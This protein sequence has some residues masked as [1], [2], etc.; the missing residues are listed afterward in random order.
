MDVL[1]QNRLLNFFKG[2]LFCIYVR[3]TQYACTN[4]SPDP[5]IVFLHSTAD[6]KTSSYGQLGIRRITVAVMTHKIWNE[7]V[8]CFTKRK[9]CMLNNIRYKM[10][11]SVTE[12]RT[13][14]LIW[15]LETGFG[16]RYSPALSSASMDLLV[17][18]PCED[19]ATEE[20][21]GHISEFFFLRVISWFPIL[22]ARQ[23]GGHINALSSAV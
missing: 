19:Y 4:P 12:R 2:F 17:R 16:C 23:I 20:C 11:K 14:V 18:K 1:Y 3:W 6:G 10:C 22:T 7:V 8:C 13:T 5:W 9:L 21:C 15:K